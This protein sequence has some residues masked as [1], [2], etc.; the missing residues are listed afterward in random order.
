MKTSRRI[1]KTPARLPASVHQQLSAYALAISAAGAAIAAVP[2]AEAK[3][4]YT[5]THHILTNGTL[6]IPIAGTASFN[7]T[8]KSYIIT[9]S[10]TSQILDINATGNAAVVAGAHGSASPLPRGKVI[11]PADKF[12]TGKVFMAEAFRETQISSSK[13]FGPFANITHRYLGLKFKLH[14]KVHY[15]WARFSAVTAGFPDGVPTVSATLT[16]YAYETIPNKPIV[17]G[18][19]KGADEIGSEKQDAAFAM[20]TRQPASLGL[21]ALG[22][23]GLSIWRREELMDERRRSTSDFWRRAVYGF[24][25]RTS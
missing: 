25:R 12:Q 14:G 8:D 3:I 19:T 9:G 13:A 18:K 11:G 4:I 10:W 5:P 16:G 2:P 15:G 7:L 22:S 21:L 24:R 17:A 1:H 6:P 20:P 23:S